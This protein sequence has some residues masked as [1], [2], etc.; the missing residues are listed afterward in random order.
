[1][2]PSRRGIL[3]KLDAGPLFPRPGCTSG[4]EINDAGNQI[5]NVGQHN[6]HPAKGI[7]AGKSVFTV[8]LHI[9]LP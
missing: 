4:N 6:G 5:H 2:V 9:S 8:Q 1:M 7:V 3:R